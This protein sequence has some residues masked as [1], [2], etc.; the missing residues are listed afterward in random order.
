MKK[1]LMILIL[2][3]G[4][5]GAGAGYYL[6]YMKP[7]QDAT[8]QDSA[9]K[10]KKPVLANTSTAQPDETAAVN[11]NTHFYVNEHKLAIRN[12]PDPESFPV[13]YL[14]KGDPIT[15]LEQKQGWGRI[16]RY[17]V[18]QQGGPE[19]AEWV[20]MDQLSEQV[21]IISKEEKEEILMSYINKSD[22]LLIYKEKFLQ[23][24]GQLID[25]K[26]CAPEDFDELKGWVRSVRYQERHVY[27][28]YCGGLKSIDKI[29]FD[30]DSGEIFY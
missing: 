12:A 23:I 25:E 8:E 1:I 22:D 5:G 30:A 20:A 10:K 19:I 29:Y 16:S 18:Y 7:H 2:L 11:V 6:F 24:T 17:F 21:P 28:I 26:M 3:L 15:V 9:K 27:F 4:V 13:R 14:Y